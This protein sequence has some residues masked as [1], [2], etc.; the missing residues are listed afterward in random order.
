MIKNQRGFTLL[1]FVFTVLILGLLALFAA[2][3]FHKLMVK[4][5][6]NSDLYRIYS[7]IQ[8]AQ[9]IAALSA[10]P[11][12]IIPDPNRSTVTYPDSG[13]KKEKQVKKRAYWGQ[14]FI[15]TGYIPE[16]LYY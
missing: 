2:P 15:M 1:E 6:M 3:A 8:E 7:S 11:V 16:K 14:E 4:E 5:R 10:R 12:I 13:N 9:E